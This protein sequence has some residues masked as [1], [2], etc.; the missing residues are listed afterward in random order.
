[1][2]RTPYP[3][4]RMIRL[5]IVLVAVVIAGSACSGAGLPGRRTREPAAPAQAPPHPV[6]SVTI[7][8]FGTPGLR[9]EGSYGEL[10]DTKSVGG[11]VPAR[12]TFDT[13]VG[14]TVAL[15]KRSNEG[16]LGI[17]VTVAGRVVNQVSTRKE[18]GLVTYTQRVP[19]R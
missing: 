17:K 11:T 13:A 1:M 16:E 8:V 6:T 4:I 7:E 18:Y 14:F 3:M 5:A 19:T 10:G 9:F 15:Q 2:V 12:L